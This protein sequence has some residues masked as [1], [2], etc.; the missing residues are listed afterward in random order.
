NRR[1]L[2][3]DGKGTFARYSATRDPAVRDQPEGLI[4]PWLKV[5]SFWNGEEPL[6]AINAY[7]T[8]PMSHYG[9]GAISSDFVGLARDRRRTDQPAIHQIYVSGCSGD[10]TAGKYNDGSP[11]N[12]A[13]LT[14]R[15]YAAMNE[16]MTATVR[17]PLTKIDF[18][19]ASLLLPHREG[20]QTADALRSRL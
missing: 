20:D 5:I 13:R 18:R 14:E 11:E 10:V 12:R 9:Q 19:T 15:M 6:A 1:V 2:G 4:D 8:H 17:H 7:A 3:A 16:A